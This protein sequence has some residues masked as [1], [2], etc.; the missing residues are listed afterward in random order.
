MTEG[1]IFFFCWVDYLATRQ[2]EF[3]WKAYLLA[4][5]LTPVAISFLLGLSIY[6]FNR[7]LYGRD[8]AAAAHAGE[9]SINRFDEAL[10]SLQQVPFLV[11]LLL[12]VLG[13]GVIYNLD[14]IVAF[15][16]RAG[17]QAL[18]YLL[19]S[20]A[21]GVMITTLV[22][23]V[24]M[25]L[26]YR[27]RCRRLDYLHHY[28]TQ[29]LDRTGL[30]MLEDETVIDRDGKVVERDPQ[31]LIGNQLRSDELTLLPRLGRKK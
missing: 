4:A 25:V 14:A 29:V 26:S 3:P 12:L 28:R 7:Y 6:G 2:L 31:G 20:L 1:L 30:I 17:E 11:T 15:L 18:R 8:P 21:G 10:H 19:W 23:L 27:L 24:W 5:F 9:G 16:S 22:A 13:G